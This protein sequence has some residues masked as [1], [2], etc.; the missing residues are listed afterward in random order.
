M[1]T[2]GT[3]EKSREAGKGNDIWKILRQQEGGRGGNDK[4]NLKV[5]VRRGED[6]NRKKGMTADMDEKKEKETKRKTEVVS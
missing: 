6:K 5:P 2:R 3:I 1:N 4:H